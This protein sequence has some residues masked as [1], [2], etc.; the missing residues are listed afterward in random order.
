M[1]ELYVLLNNPVHASIAGT[2]SGYALRNL[3]EEESISLEDL[4]FKDDVKSDISDKQG[5]VIF[6]DVTFSP[7]SVREHAILTEFALGLLATDGRATPAIAASFSH[8][9]CIA[10]QLLPN[11][12]D[13]QSEL[14]F[15]P[16]ISQPAISQ[17]LRLCAQAARKAGKVFLITGLRF[18]RYLKSED[19]F[20]ATLDLSIALE[21]LLSAQ[22]E[23]SFRFS[24]CLARIA[25]EKG[26]DGEESYNLLKKLYDLRS[27]IAHGDP[28]AGKLLKQLEQDNGMARLRQTSRTILTAY[29]IFLQ[30]HSQK[31]WK[32][33]LT[34]QLIK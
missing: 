7:D 2:H 29:V 24:V 26:A 3:R 4:L 19:P 13:P 31:E 27:K 18:S 11:A 25:A 16:A 12:N 20:D 1:A 22:S 8:G 6:P 14:T 9:K 17:W 15:P 33:M 34:H 5:V 28:E 21:S 10:A 30:D 23:I 32:E